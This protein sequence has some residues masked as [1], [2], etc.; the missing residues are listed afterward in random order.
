MPDPLIEWVD[1]RL[2]SKRFRDI[3]FDSDGPAATRRVFLAPAKIIERIRAAKT[4]T[5]MEFGFGTGLNFVTLAE[6]LCDDDVNARVRYIS[7][8]KYP[9]HTTD[10][11]RAFEPFK[12]RCAL[13]GELI[14]Q[15]PPRVPGWHRRYFLGGRLELSLCYGEVGDALNE[16]ADCDDRGVDA[17][18]L[19]GFAPDRNP[20]MWE[21]ALFERMRDITNPHGT[22]TTFSAAGSVRRALQDS[23]FQVE[24]VRDTDAPKRHTTLAILA[25]DAFKPQHPPDCVRVVGGGLAGATMAHTLALKGLRVELFE[26]AATVGSVTSSI[27]AA[28]QHP[29]LSAAATVSALFRIH[30]YT[31]A[32]SLLNKA[33]AV[34]TIGA[35]HLPDAGMLLH[36]LE[37]ISNLVGTSWSEMLDAKTMQERTR[38]LVDSAGAWYP[39]SAVVNCASLCETLL[40]NERIS[41]FLQSELD[42]STDNEVPTVY[43]TGCDIPQPIGDMPIEAIA[44]PGQVDAF[45]I[46]QAQLPLRHVLVN[47][48][49]VAPRD[50][51]LFAGSTYEY[52][53]WSGGEAMR[54]NKERITN[55]HPN[56][57]FQHRFSFRATR[58]VTSDRLP[59]VGAIGEQSWAS[60][61]H[62]SGG[63]ITAPFAAELIASDILHEMPI[64]SPEFKRLLAPERF[65]LRQQRRPDPLTRGLRGKK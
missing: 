46:D 25:A 27:P 39:K 55:L 52:R 35:I 5:I 7:V 62:G 28:I 19:D 15:L 45:L 36:R 54:A 57:R 24:R 8:D 6:T 17:W 3:Y 51:L 11:H 44:I 9:L 16:F 20:T 22:V 4:F 41:V 42:I 33:D 23:G 18:F 2:R 14:S 65:Y 38:K 37:D 40:A 32:Y 63:T 26:R 1:G 34:D 61:A 21:R 10:L 60:W 49:Y 64:G 31:H 58:V 48:G 56:C 50:E 12:T 43:A 47:N 30:A 13:A 29:R 53:P 59:I